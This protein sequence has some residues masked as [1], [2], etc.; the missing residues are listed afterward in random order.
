MARDRKFD[1]E[2][3]KEILDQNFIEIDEEFGGNKIKPD[4]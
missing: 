4:E 1:P 3:M 2:R